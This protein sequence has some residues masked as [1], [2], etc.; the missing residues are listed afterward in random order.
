MKRW[1]QIKWKSGIVNGIVIFPSS[2]PFLFLFLF[3]LLLK[4]GRTGSRLEIASYIKQ[5]WNHLLYFLPNH[6]SV[7]FCLCLRLRYKDLDSWVGLLSGIKVL[8]QWI[9]IHRVSNITMRSKTTLPQDIDHMVV[10]MMGHSPE[11][12]ISCYIG[13]AESWMG[14]GRLY[15]DVGQ[16]PCWV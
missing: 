5:K 6:V 2:L 15:F 8:M 14:I 7:F 4:D 11:Q 16:G 1:V 3:L 12:L 9:V 10:D 13:L